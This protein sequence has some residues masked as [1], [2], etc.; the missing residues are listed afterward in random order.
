M[1]KTAVNRRTAD[2]MTANKKIHA[3]PLYISIPSAV[4]MRRERTDHVDKID[5]GRE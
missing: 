4:R 3:S 2:M 5:S 1:K